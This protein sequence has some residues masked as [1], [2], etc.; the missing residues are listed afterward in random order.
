MRSPNEVLYSWFRT[1][2][3][4]YSPQLVHNHLADLK[5]DW[6]GIYA[7]RARAYPLMKE[8]EAGKDKRA[9]KTSPRGHI[10]YLVGYVSSNIYRIWVPKLDRVIVSRNVTFNEDKS[11]SEK[12]D[13]LQ[14]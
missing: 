13:P 4:W 14:G 12:I 2:F 3:R 6:D 7:Y 9:F 8:R 1:Y 11:Y 10:G 5:P